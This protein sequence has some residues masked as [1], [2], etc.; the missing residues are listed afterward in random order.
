MDGNNGIVR[1]FDFDGP[2]VPT[3][4]ARAY[5]EE[6]GPLGLRGAT[7]DSVFDDYVAMCAEGR[8]P[9]VPQRVFVR[10]LAQYGLRVES[11]RLGGRATQVIMPCTGPIGLP[12]AGTSADASVRAFI[13]RGGVRDGTPVSEVPEMYV[14]FC[15]EENLVPVH[16]GRT[17]MRAVY[18]ATGWSSRTVKANGRA[19]RVIDA[20]ER[21]SDARGRRDGLRYVH[22]DESPWRAVLVPQNGKY[23]RRG[24]KKRGPPV[25]SR[26][27]RPWPVRA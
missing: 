9:P 13:E 6:E 17:L 8:E 16:G 12:T 15:A 3:D 27:P 18:S 23:A 7:F 20:R 24:E 4:G 22:E 2:I 21:R 19:V 25:G 1:V 11:Y 14:R 5:I 26:S 10:M